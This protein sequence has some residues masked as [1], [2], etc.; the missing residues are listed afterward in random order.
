MI[1]QTLTI[2]D[3]A[4]A[5]GVS[6]ATVSRVLR[7]CGNVSDEKVDKVN[8]IIKQ[9]NYIPNVAARRMHGFGMKT[10]A[11]VTMRTSGQA[12]GNPYFS[13]ITGEIGTVAAKRGYN[14]QINSFENVETEVSKGIELYSS[15]QVHGFLLLSSRV[16]D[17]MIYRLAQEG[18]PFVIIGRVIENTMPNYQDIHWINTDNVSSSRMAV[19]YLIDKGHRNIG[20]LTGPMKYVVSQDRYM[21][22]RQA[23]V[24]H[25]LPFHE[26]YAVSGE[27]SLHQAMEATRKMLGDNPEITAIFATDDLKAIA[28]LEVLHQ[29]GKRLPQDVSV[30]GFD[31]FDISQIVHPKLTTIEVPIVQMGYQATN[32][33]ISLIEGEEVPE[34][35]IIMDTKLIERESVSEVC[36]Q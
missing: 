7:N 10:I 14:L 8:R 35:H 9:F 16:Y 28:A 20:I 6:V 18:I 29:M 22:Y 15:G 21:G 36:A 4:A 24:T 5:A 2:K 30:I 25:N 31:N 34:K 11:L 3:V 26:S 23:L 33:L 12:F 17:P 19:D 27:Y 32:M 13:L 1:N